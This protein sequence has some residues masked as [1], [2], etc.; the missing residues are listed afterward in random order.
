MEFQGKI[1][2]RGGVE[3]SNALTASAHSSPTAHLFFLLLAGVISYLQ[4]PAT[5]IEW[6]AIKGRLTNTAERK[7]LDAAGEWHVF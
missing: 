6:R 2:K 1:R 7:L 5:G 3:E 4:P